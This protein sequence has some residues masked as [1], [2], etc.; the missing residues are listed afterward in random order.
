MMK[1]G[2]GSVMFWGCFSWFGV[3]PLVHVEGTLK[4]KDY[5]GLLERHY[6]PWA[7]DLVSKEDSYPSLI[8]QQDNAT[9]H[10]AKYTK[11]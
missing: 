11:K 7:R 8:F 2:G 1:F 10:T 4:A 9:V 3:G 5:V 6:I